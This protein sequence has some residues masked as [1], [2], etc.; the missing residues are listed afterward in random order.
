LLP[1]IQ[2]SINPFIYCFMSANFRR[3]MRNACNRCCAWS[4][5]SRGCTRKSRNAEFDMETKSVNGT[6][7]YSPTSVTNGRPGITTYSS[8]VSECWSAWSWM[9]YLHK[10]PQTERPQFT[11]VKIS[12]NMN[13]RAFEL[14]VLDCIADS[15]CVVILP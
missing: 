7:K 6:S 2:S 4:K 1:F 10:G 5:V 15:L 3:S 8:V 11:L 12:W 9:D 13:N 14:P